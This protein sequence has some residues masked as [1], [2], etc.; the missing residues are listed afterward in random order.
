MSRVVTQKPSAAWTAA[1]IAVLA[2]TAAYVLTAIGLS[3]PLQSANDRSRW[4]TVWSLGERGTW[5][6]DEIDQNP[7]WSTIDK[8]RHRESED[9]PWH[10]YSS[11]P[12]LLSVAVT[13]LYLIE[14][15]TLGYS[16]TDHTVTVTRLLLVLINGIPMIA[17]L[18][19]FRRNL[20]LLGASGAAVAAMLLI[21]GFGTMLNPYLTT[22]NNHTPGAVSLMFCLTAMNRLRLCRESLRRDMAVIGFTAALTVCFELPAALFGILSF[23]FVLLTI[24]GSSLNRAAVAQRDETRDAAVPISEF[25]T[26]GRMFRNV[27][28]MI[29]W[30]KD[31]LQNVRLAAVSYVP[32]ALIPLAAFFVTNIDCTGGVKP[33]YA[34]YGT[35]KYRY[36]HEG[37]PSYWMDPQGMDAN[38]ESTG[39]Y[40]FHCVLGHHG[41]LSLSPI[42]L[43]TPAGWWMSLRRKASGANGT[44]AAEF[45]FPVIGSVLTVVVLAFYL[46]RTQ[47]YNYG[48]NSAA[49]R[50]MLWLIPLWLYGMVPIVDRLLRRKRGW[51]AVFALLIPSAWSSFYSLQTPWRPNWIFQQL[52]DAGV[53]DYRTRI[54]PFSPPRYT[55]LSAIPDQPMIKCVWKEVDSGR[56]LTMQTLPAQS[57]DPVGWKRLSYSLQNDSEDSFRPDRGELLYSAE[58]FSSG[59]DLSDWLKSSPVSG[60]TSPATQNTSMSAEDL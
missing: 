55:V 27:C 3:Q 45:S 34:Y 43:L 35:E 37:I 17:A 5:Y 51:I 44:R 19:S 52:E 23:L 4:C 38:Q 15:A 36:V 59:A 58:R 54:P 24:S 2:V 29:P 25:P 50:W 9:Q 56:T 33:F 6:I 31:L 13:G 16:L 41:L 46:S 18:C 60:A 14:K 8:V 30:G 10:F 1:E 40:L 57:A 48:G 21:A 11:K 28:D 12:P 53:I 26:A 20:H 7:A 22:L 42:L 32:A 39:T 49:L 47:N